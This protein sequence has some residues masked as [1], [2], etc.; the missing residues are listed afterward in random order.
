VRTGLGHHPVGLRLGVGQ[1]PVGLGA[2]MAQQRL[3]LGAGAVDGGV[4]VIL[5][6]LQHRVA[7]V[8]H[9]LRVVQLAWDGVLDVVDQFQDVAARN[10]AAGRHRNT[11]GFFDDGAQFIERFKNSVHGALPAVVGSDQCACCYACEW[12]GDTGVSQM[13]THAL[14]EERCRHP[15]E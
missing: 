7:G 6:L 9:V 14:S 12:C 8:E 4:G 10:H 5:G 3:G 13:S 11:T 2:G 1:Q 15:L